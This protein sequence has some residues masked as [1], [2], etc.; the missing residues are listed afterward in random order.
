MRRQIDVR[1]EVDKAPPRQTD[2]FAVVLEEKLVALSSSANLE[3]S[4][5][6]ASIGFISAEAELFLLLSNE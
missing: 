4:Y 1:S 5:L 6:R 3:P 2:I